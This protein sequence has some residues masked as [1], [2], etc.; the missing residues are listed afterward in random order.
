MPR[1]RS[2]YKELKAFG[3]RRCPPRGIPSWEGHP[4]LLSPAQPCSAA[5]PHLS[6]HARLSQPRSR[7]AQPTE[8]RSGTATRRARPPASLRQGGCRAG[9]RPEIPRGLGLGRVPPVPQPRS[10]RSRSPGSDPAPGPARL[11]PGSADTVAKT[12]T[13]PGSSPGSHLTPDPLLPLAAPWR[14]SVSIGSCACPSA[15]PRPPPVGG[16]IASAR[17]RWELTNRKKRC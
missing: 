3:P 5:H 13:A 17:N 1:R 14:S 9:K 4:P 8:R 12:L 16:P 10:P 11:P 2:S 7:S 15:S 6:Q